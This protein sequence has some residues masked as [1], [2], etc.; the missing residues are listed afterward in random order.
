MFKKL[1]FFGFIL[2]VALFSGCKKDKIFSKD[3]LDFSKDTVLFDTVFTTVGST[4]KSFRI[5][6]NNNAKIL[7]EEI[8]LMGGENSPF[9]INID[10]VSGLSFEDVIIPRNDSLFVFVEVT[11]EVN[12]TT[13]PLVISDSI[14]FRT[15]GLD[16][17]VFL[18][19]WGQDA[20][21]HVNEIVSGTWANDK[22][23]VIYGIAAVGYPGLDSNL[24]LTIPQGT[25]VYCH[26]D[27]MLLVYKSKLEIQGQYQNEVIFQGDRLESFYDDK[28]GQW[29]GIRLI[30]A[31]QST[32]DYAIIKNGSIGVQVDTTQDPLTLSLENT[33]I[34]NSDFFNLYLVA[35]AHVMAENCIFGDAG[36]YSA[37]FFAGGEY[38]FKNCHFANYWNGSRGGPAFALKN[39]YETDDAT[40]VRD[41]LNSRFDNCIIYGTAE[42]ELEI[43][44]IP[45]AVY[46]CIF[47]HNLIRRKD[48]YTYSNYLSVQW[49]LDPQF[50]DPS[51]GDL[52]ISSSS[53][54][55]NAGDPA[56]A[57]LLDIEG[58]ARNLSTPDLG[59]YELP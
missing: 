23:H 15:N 48:T 7:V 13:N 54:A 30:E 41:V 43:D 25:E 20:Y 33:I 2:L 35:G 3:H 40:Y 45:G 24:T 12:N 53:P 21:F 8:E 39:W 47:N 55:N 57:T 44:T 1:I 14:R 51:N 58:V 32:I 27:A 6:N 17:Y 10:G 49:N 22:P 38:Q 28:P 34:T 36:L 19:V 52:H 11:L 50:L 29:W 42:N 26:K 56:F 4:T 31:Q 16:Q 37:F 18:D 5:Y 59:V 9:R 46:D